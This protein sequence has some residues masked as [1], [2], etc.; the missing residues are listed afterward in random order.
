MNINRENMVYISLYFVKSM[1]KC[2]CIYVNADT[3][4]CDL[5]QNQRNIYHI[6]GQAS[7]NILFCNSHINI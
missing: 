1:R 3:Y 4:P 5:E 7:V 6:F 2:L